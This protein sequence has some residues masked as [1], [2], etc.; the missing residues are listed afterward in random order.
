MDKP[1]RHVL[2][3]RVEPP[4]SCPL[5]YECHHCAFDQ[6]VEDTEDL[7]Q[8][9]NRPVCSNVSGVP[10]ADDYYYHPGHSWIRFEHGGRLRVGMDGF[11]ARL[12]GPLESI[13]LPAL[14]SDLTQTEVGW[15]IH[16]QA[17]SAGV[18]VPVSGTV[19]ALNPVIADHPEMPHHDPYQHGWLMLMESPHPKRGLKHLMMGKAVFDWMESETQALVDLLGEDYLSLTATGGRLAE[20]LVGRVAGLDW[21]RLVR[22]FLR[23]EP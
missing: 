6:W 10:V 4:K 9:A 3:G 1:C 16:R 14:G 7:V 21:D 18:Q 2:T 20:D 8:D 12:F 15:R 23:T 19:V 5:N 22:R 13:E 11:A 17:R